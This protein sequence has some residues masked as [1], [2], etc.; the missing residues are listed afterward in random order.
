VLFSEK[1]EEDASLEK[2][3]KDAGNVVLGF[4]LT[5]QLFPIAPFREKAIGIGYFHPKKNPYNDTVYSIIPQEA[6]NRAFSFEILGKYFDTAPEQA[7]NSL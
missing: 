3:I 7:K 2:S 4:S 6:G 1:S 5:E